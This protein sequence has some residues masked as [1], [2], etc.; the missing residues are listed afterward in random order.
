MLNSERW[1][2]SLSTGNCPSLRKKNCFCTTDCS[3]GTRY[4][5]TKAPFWVTK[6]SG[7]IPM[8]EV[9]CGEGEGWGLMGAISFCDSLYAPTAPPPCALSND[10]LGHV[11]KISWSLALSARSNYFLSYGH[12][13]PFI[14]N[15]FVYG[16]ERIFLFGNALCLII[17]IIYSSL[18]SPQP[19]TKTTATAFTNCPIG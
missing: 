9:G 7:P 8:S 18:S 17:R 3:N 13:L 11:M 15:R 6:T 4:K 16:W 10:Q 5:V 19:S 1:N 12:L 2:V 14:P